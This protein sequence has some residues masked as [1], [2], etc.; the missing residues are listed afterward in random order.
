VTGRDDGQIAELVQY[1]RD[2][3]LLGKGIEARSRFVEKKD[4]LTRNP[5]DAARQ[6]EP[7]SL[8]H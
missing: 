4:I 5:Q 2:Y 7:L 3:L 8:S 6:G 1:A